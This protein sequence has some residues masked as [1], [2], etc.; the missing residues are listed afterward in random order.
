MGRLLSSIAPLW[1]RVSLPVGCRP[2]VQEGAD[3]RDVAVELF[4]PDAVASAWDIGDL[5][6]QHL[7]LHCGGHLW[8]ND[9]AAVKISGDQ[10]RRTGDAWQKLRPGNAVGG[11]ELCGA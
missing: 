3:N 4:T 10:E 9:R 8:P 1:A 7:L 5:E 11:V 2:G 6:L